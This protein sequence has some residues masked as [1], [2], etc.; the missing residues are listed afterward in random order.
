MHILMDN[1]Q[2]KV[3]E[4]I[5]RGTKIGSYDSKDEENKNSYMMFNEIH[6][7]V[8]AGCELY[9]DG[10]ISWDDAMDE[11]CTLIER[12]KGKEKVLKDSADKE[13]T[14]EPAEE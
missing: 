1:G 13:E 4:E 2:E 8:S 11:L 10:K 5:I 14:D 9:K 3:A 6:E 7:F 12:M